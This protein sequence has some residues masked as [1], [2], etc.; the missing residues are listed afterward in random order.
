MTE[1]QKLFD[2]LNNLMPSDPND[3]YTYGTDGS[4]EALYEKFENAFFELFTFT[5][6]IIE[7]MRYKEMQNG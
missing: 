4:Y 3:D 6:D 7:N 5:E 1:A 2:E